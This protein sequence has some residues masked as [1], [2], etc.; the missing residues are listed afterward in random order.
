MKFNH[1]ATHMKRFI[2][3]AKIIKKSKT[4]VVAVYINSR[5]L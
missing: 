2:K 4:E 3:N 5:S 1:Y